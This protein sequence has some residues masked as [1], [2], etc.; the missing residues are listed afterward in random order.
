MKNGLI[1][2]G[3]IMIILAIVGFAM[4]GFKVTETKN[5][6]DLGPIQ[7]N[8]KEEH[9]FPIPPIVSY[10]LLAGGAACVIGGA[11]TKSGA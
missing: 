6:V 11:M 2:I 3:V 9:R 1:I 7:V 10:A 5:V 8:A 4:G